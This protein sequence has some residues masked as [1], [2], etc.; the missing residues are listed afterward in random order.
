MQLDHLSE[1]EVTDGQRE[2]PGPSPAVIPQQWT[3]IAGELERVVHRV[4]LLHKLLAVGVWQF[5]RL[6]LRFH[7][8]FSFLLTHRLLGIDQ[9]FTLRQLR[10]FV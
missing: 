8:V 7:I 10:L 2:Q 5:S 4:L 6:H 3:A 1:M 9:A